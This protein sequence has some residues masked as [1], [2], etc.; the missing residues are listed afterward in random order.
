MPNTRNTLLLIWTGASALIAIALYMQYV[1]AL[2][3]CALCM[4]QRVFII[5]LGAVALLAWL[6][7][8]GSIGLRSYALTGTLLAVIGAGFSGRHIW[9]QN[10]PEDRVPSCGPSLGYLLDTVPFLE[11]LSVLLQGDGHCAEVSW[12]LLGL[13]IPSWTL[14][15]FAGLFFANCW[16][17]YKSF[18]Q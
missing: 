1:M 4:T 5:A 10:L 3:P 14:L 13:S 9:L 7:K 15:A 12:Q 2:A 18:R 11:A 8:P 17:F 16:I 6:H